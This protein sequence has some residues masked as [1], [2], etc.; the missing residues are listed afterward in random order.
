VNAAVRLDRVCKVYNA[1]ERQIVALDYVDIEIQSS[2]F[3]SI[4][5]PSGCGKTT[6]LRLIAGL[7]RP[8]EGVVW[9]NGRAIDEPAT[10]LGIVFQEPT[11]LDWR[12]VLEN[13][14]IQVDVR[15]LPRQPYEQ[16][17]RE[18]LKRLGLS[19]FE[20]SYP[21]RLSGGMR[22]RVGIARA[23]VHNPPLLLMDEPFSALD[24]LTRDRLNVDL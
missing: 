15:R 16:C 4:L 13:V 24:A 19:G 14:M 3:V 22:Q 8:T 1:A 12:R 21:L 17:A 7:D 5:G 10:D 6:L 23:L 20:R 2:E 9:V 11:L 18:L